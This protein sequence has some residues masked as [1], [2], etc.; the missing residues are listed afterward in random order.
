MIGL[1]KGQTGPSP[2]LNH[3][4]NVNNLVWPKTPGNL[5]CFYQTGYSRGFQKL[6]EGQNFLWNVRGLNINLLLNSITDKS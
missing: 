1:C 5:R 4:V 6:L 3:I 2:H